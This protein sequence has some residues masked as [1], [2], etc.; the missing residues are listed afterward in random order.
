MMDKKTPEFTPCLLVK[1]KKNGARQERIT[2][3]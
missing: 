2:H 1:K 3:E